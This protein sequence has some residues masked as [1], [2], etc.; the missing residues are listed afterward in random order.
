MA[1]ASAEGLGTVVGLWR[2]PVKSMMGEE[3][4]ASDVTTR[5][6]IGDR[7]Y[8]LIDAESG[9]VVSAKNPRKWPALF[10]FRAAYCDVPRDASALPPAR[11]TSP[12]G[13]QIRTDQA[14][15][16]ERLSE[17]V[18]RAVKLASS[19]PEAPTIEGY[20]PDHEWLQNRD[21][22]FDVNLP[23]GTFFDQT[24]V[25]LVTTATLDRLR[26]LAPGSRFEARRFRPNVVITPPAGMEGFVEDQWIGRTL[27]IGA[28]VVLRVTD[29]CPRCVMT[30]LSQ[31]DL[32]K[33]P[34]VLR[35]CVEHNKGNVGVCASVVQG[36]RVRRGDFVTEA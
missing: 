6:L 24:A 3:L 35:A 12:T 5:G 36:G 13:E 8:A 34:S 15:A 27:R 19:A 32:P 9:K 23:P 7:A 31:G 10:D 18:G 4:N 21:E 26:S 22:T 33:D 20:W 1:S 17:G 11:I 29:I 25:H 14:D 28:E 2:Y 16:S 30:T